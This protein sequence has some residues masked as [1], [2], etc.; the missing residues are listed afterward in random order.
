MSEI[1]SK[2]KRKYLYSV[3]IFIK[4]NGCKRPRLP[5]HIGFKAIEYKE[6]IVIIIVS[7]VGHNYLKN[8][9]YAKLLEVM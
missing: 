7:L 4:K 1:Y 2:Y 8:R 3:P 5:K 6:Q 9:K